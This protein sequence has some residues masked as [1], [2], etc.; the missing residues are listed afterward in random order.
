MESVCHLSTCKL[1]KRI[2]EQLLKILKISI[3]KLKGAFNKVFSND[4]DYEHLMKKIIFWLQN[5]LCRVELRHILVM[6]EV[7][8]E[9]VE[10]EVEEE[11]AIGEDEA[12]TEEE[13]GEDSN[14][15]ETD[16]DDDDDDDENN[17]GDGEDDKYDDEEEN[18]EWNET[19]PDD[20]NIGN[21]LID[22]SETDITSSKKF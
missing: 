7:E 19:D 3:H 20:D 9:A 12:V 6:W 21:G 8:Y 16:D 14:N 15:M 4:Y 17:D 13:E 1:E 11:V 2:L 18:D 5:L 10:K 22:L